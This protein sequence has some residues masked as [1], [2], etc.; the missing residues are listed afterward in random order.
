V[1]RP[2]LNPAGGLRYHLRGFRYAET[3]WQPFRW[4]LGE[5]L[6]GWE[7][8][9]KKLIV[10][11]SSGGWCVQPF[12]FE[13]FAEVTCLEPDP[14]AH[15]IFRRRLDKAPLDSRPRL[16]FEAEDHLLADPSKLLRLLEAEPQSAVLFTNIVGQ[17]RVLLGAENGDEPGF[18]RVR[19]AVQS[20]IPSR[21][22]ASF[23]D[24]VS[25]AI[26]PAIDGA[27]HADSRLGDAELIEHFY[28]V[29]EGVGGP[30][31]VTPGID[32]AGQRELLDHLTDGFFPASRPHSYFSWQLLPGTFHLI[33]ATR[34][35]RP[36]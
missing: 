14:I 35:V 9:E 17:L 4:H 28:P 3:L 7:P 16:R 24:R 30:R 18:V 26:E 23:H 19:E 22:F 8:P 15:R 25:G 20:V 36:A 12:F 5:W 31:P 34:G 29:Y 33:E 2:W 10:V 13:R 21:S 6:Y 32:R 11:G 27:V 1:S